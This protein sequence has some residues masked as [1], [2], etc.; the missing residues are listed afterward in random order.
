MEH[1]GETVALIVT[2]LNEEASLARFLSGID[3]NLEDVTEVVIVD[4]GSS[5]GTWDALASWAAV[6]EPVVKLVRA[7]GAGIAAGRNIGITNSTGARIAVTDGGCRV[8][9]GW[10][11]A[12]TAPLADEEIVA[13]K[14]SYVG[15]GE[16]PLGRAVA[17]VLV[18]DLQTLRKE[19]TMPSSRSLAFRRAA[20]EQVGGY[21]EWLATAED[22]WFAQQLAATGP[23]VFAP[24][25][26]VEWLVPNRLGRVVRQYVRY[27]FGDGRAGTNTRRLVVM[28]LFYL[29]SAASM[30]SLPSRIAAVGAHAMYLWRRTRGGSRLSRLRPLEKALAVTAIW[31]SD[32]ALVGGFA[33]GLATKPRRAGGS[34]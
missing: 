22:T 28:G 33:F 8:R 15:K 3:A 32:L 30:L 19:A 14:G 7:P 10:V 34:R 11:E 4:G 2:V 18:N 23:I 1:A 27:G 29:V 20:W 21:P 25:A 6:R 31:V 9:P 17:A 24:D 26:V 13:V 5:D 16:S 12:I